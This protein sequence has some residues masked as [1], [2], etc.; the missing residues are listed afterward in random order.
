MRQGECEGGEISECMSTYRRQNAMRAC[1]QL[2]MDDTLTDRAI[3]SD[4]GPIAFRARC[5]GTRL[6]TEIQE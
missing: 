2:E 1:G 5:P 3:L 6:P 4:G